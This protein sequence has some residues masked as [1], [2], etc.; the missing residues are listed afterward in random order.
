[1]A[2]MNSKFLPFSRY[3]GDALPETETEEEAEAGA[4]AE[5]RENRSRE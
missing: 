4:E 5:K 3:I 2:K 1:M